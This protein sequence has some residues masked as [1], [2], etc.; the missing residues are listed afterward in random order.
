MFHC[1]SVTAIFPLASI[2]R[3]RNCVRYAVSDTFWWSVGTSDEQGSQRNDAGDESQ[4][5]IDVHTTPSPTV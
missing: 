2:L 5:Y 4:F 3:L 1:K